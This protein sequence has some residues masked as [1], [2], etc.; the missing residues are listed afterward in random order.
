MSQFSVYKNRN[1]K[2]RKIF[3]YLLD[4]QSDLLE[5]IRT[6][7]VVPLGKY[8]AVKDQVITTLCP[9]VEIDGIEYAALTQQLAGI[10]RRLLGA[11]VTNISNY[12]ADIIA[13]IDLIVSGI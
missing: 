6:T 11:E 9:I 7:V 12:R 1:P 3:P 8:S 5:Q 10:D 2:T 4:I 13:A